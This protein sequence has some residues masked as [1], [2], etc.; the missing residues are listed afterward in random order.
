MDLL[1]FVVSPSI[2]VSRLNDP[3]I[4]YLTSKLALC[5]ILCRGF[6]RPLLGDVWGK[7]TN[8]GLG[9][10]VQNSQ[11]FLV[12]NLRSQRTCLTSI[13]KHRKDSNNKLKPSFLRGINHTFTAFC[14]LFRQ[15]NITKVMI[16]SPCMGYLYTYMN[17]LHVCYISWVNIPVP[18]SLWGWC[19]AELPSTSP[20]LLAKP[21]DDFNQPINVVTWE[22][23]WKPM[24]GDIFLAQNPY[25]SAK[26]SSFFPAIGRELKSELE[27]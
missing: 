17:G 27:S 20:M 1:L 23:H 18:W 4:S 12:S 8:L 2:W 22:N 21:R 5:R 9:F 14:P 15:K 16:K 25:R 11:N 6:F 7:K 24:S 10:F 19:L 3:Y 26:K 13:V